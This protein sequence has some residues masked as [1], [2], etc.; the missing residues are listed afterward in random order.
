LTPGQRKFNKALSS[1][2]IAVEQAFG[3]AQVLWTYT[4]FAKGL[5]AGTQPLA[6]QFYV[7]VLLMNCHTCFNG[8]AAG[9]RFLVPPPTVEEYLELDDERVYEMGL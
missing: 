2:R 5:T 1:V 9:N 3:R 8:S 6:A 4:A 7:A